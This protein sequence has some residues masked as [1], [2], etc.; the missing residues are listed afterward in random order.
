M[1]YAHYDRLSATDATFLA[2]E[3][4]T[5]HMHVGS[6]GIFDARPL[7]KPEGGLDMDRILA[8]SDVALSKSPRFRQKITQIPG[9]GHPVWVDDDKFN[10]AYHV[11]QTALPE[12]GTIR[13]LKRLS[14]R[15]MSQELDQGKPLW[16]M[17]FV[18]GLEGNRFA[19]I[20]KF[21][22][23]LADG[24][25]GA[26]LL[27]VLMGPNANYKPKNLKK[28]MPRPA[29]GRTRLWADEV[30]RRAFLPWTILRSTRDAIAAPGEAWD[31]LRDRIEGVAETVAVSVTPASVTPLNND[32]GPHRRFDWTR[33]DLDEV[34]DLKNRLGGTVNDVVLA[35]VSGAVRQFLK[36][37]NVSVED[38]FFRAMVPVNIRTSAERGSRGKL[39]NRITIVPAELPIGEE[40][41]S[42]RL[43]A[44]KKTMAGIKGSKQIVGG[45]TLAQVA[46]WTSTGLL[47]QFARLN[48]RR[49]AVNMVV[50]NVPGPQVPVYM[51]GS[52]LLEVYP[53]V[54][55][56]SNQ[57]LGVALFSYAGGLYWGFNADWDAI[58]DLHD[59]VQLI[60][61]EFQVLRRLADQK[62]AAK[63]PARTRPAKAVARPEAPEKSPPPPPAG[64]GR[65]ETTPVA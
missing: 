32:I 62:G 16:E 31:S 2:V 47:V 12:P 38:L 9:F 35:T 34:R 27:S 41:P 39:G 18:E 1:A 52:P 44:I 53:V 3:D 48:T 42:D 25:S 61:E 51:L 54:P 4:G 24:I 11:R 20:S 6:V 64:N 17:W 58:P 21:H 37:R 23:C 22:H 33:F 59:F 45:E 36:N 7:A 43:A 5:Q 50:T 15:I 49:R 26:D 29:P 65:R 30:V 57:G 14:G 46:D 63:R 40:E 19:V 8:F 56:S 55:I 13:Q 10:L 28:W 60:E